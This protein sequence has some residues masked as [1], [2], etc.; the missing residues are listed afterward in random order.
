M[1]YR[2]LAPDGG[3]TIGFKGQNFWTGAEAVSQAVLTRLRLWQGE[4]W[5]DLGT[6]LPM[7]QQV[8]GYRKTSQV[9]ENLIR[10]KVLATPGVLSILNMETI[11]ENDYRKL[12]LT[13]T[14]DTIYG[15]AV[16]SEVKF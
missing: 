1:K 2:K 3:F 11:W 5:E 16:V 10:D 8:L 15:R 12:T 7:L 4:W 9:I 13:L 6:G 14:I